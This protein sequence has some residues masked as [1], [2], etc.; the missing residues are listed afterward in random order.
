MEGQ[1]KNH[2]NYLEMCFV[3]YRV[4]EMRLLGKS[5][6]QASCLNYGIIG[7]CKTVF[8]RSMCASDVCTLWCTL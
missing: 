2:I 3:Y 7:G 4:V 6:C 5:F 1:G 8:H